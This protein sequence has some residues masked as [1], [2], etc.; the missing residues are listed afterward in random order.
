MIP[1]P[2]GGN[3]KNKPYY[4]NERQFS[5]IY[6]AIKPIVLDMPISSVELAYLIDTFGYIYDPYHY[7]DTVGST[8]EEKRMSRMCILTDIYLKNVTHYIKE[9]KNIIEELS[10]DDMITYA[11]SLIRELAVHS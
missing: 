1:C 11:K 3:Y 7:M 8:A 2:H 4:Y 10:D 9:C 6:N 5:R